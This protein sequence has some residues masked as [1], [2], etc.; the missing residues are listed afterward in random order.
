LMGSALASLSLTAGTGML[1]AA[2]VPEIAL[3][4][5][6]HSHISRLGQD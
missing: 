6:I 2:P 3:F 1:A 4:K 5:L